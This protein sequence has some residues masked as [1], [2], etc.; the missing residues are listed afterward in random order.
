MKKL[1]FILLAFLF[2]IFILLAIPSCGNRNAGEFWT[3]GLTVNTF[4]YA[5]VRFPDGTIKTIAIK[6]WSDYSDGEQILIQTYS[7][8]YYLINSFNCIL[9][10]EGDK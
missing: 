10:Q 4:D 2:L 6:S 3:D 7:D 5:I 8:E 1:L 9:V